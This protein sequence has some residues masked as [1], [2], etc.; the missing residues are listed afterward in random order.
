PHSD[1]SSD[2]NRRSTSATIHVF[3]HPSARPGDST[4]IISKNSNSRG[5]ISPTET[6]RRPV[7]P[8]SPAVKS[9]KRSESATARPT[10]VEEPFF[11]FSSTVHR[12]YSTTKPANDADNPT[13]SLKDHA[14]F[15]SIQQALKWKAA[16]KS[17]STKKRRESFAEIPCADALLRDRDFVFL[18]DDSPSMRR[19]W[20]PLCQTL[21]VLAYMVKHFDPNGI[22]MYF[23]VLGNCSLGVTKTTELVGVARSRMPNTP[24]ELNRYKP[25]DVEKR[26]GEIVERY[27][28][29]LRE[30]KWASGGTNGRRFIGGRKEAVRKMCVFVL[31]NG[32]WED[33]TKADPLIKGLVGTLDVCD[34]PADQVGV[35]FVRFGSE[36]KGVRRL[37]RLDEGLDLSRDIVDAEPFQGGNVWKM[38]LGSLDKRWD[39]DG[40]DPMELSASGQLPAELA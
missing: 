14:T 8:T 26:L 27:C 34:K 17:N 39:D 23:T 7:S 5:A 19:H 38:L 16:L 24:T 3:A 20:D 11:A 35:Q 31:T 36:E 30:E 33:G 1:L 37:R 22:D 9:R 12:S 13:I 21:E 18:L 15:L 32:M 29:R 25:C 10:L 28:G 40:S 2:L 4:S 6:D